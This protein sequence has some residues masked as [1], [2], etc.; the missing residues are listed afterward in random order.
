MQTH[1]QNCTLSFS[2]ELNFVKLIAKKSSLIYETT[3]IIDFR[4]SSLKKISGI[5]GDVM[6]KVGFGKFCPQIKKACL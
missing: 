6:T 3:K 1:K 2:A 5:R 4:L